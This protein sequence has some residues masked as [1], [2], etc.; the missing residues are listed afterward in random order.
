MEQRHDP[1]WLSFLA[2]HLS[3]L[4]VPNLA[5]FFVAL[6]AL[7]FLLVQTDPGGFERMVLFPDKVLQ[8]ELWRLISFLAIPLAQSLIW[9]VF[10][11]LFSYFILNSIEAE[12]GEFKTTFY[13]LV[14]LVFTVIF[15]FV[16]GYPITQV[17]DF[18]ST[19]FLAAAALFPNYEIRIYF[20]FP[21][22][23][24]VLGWLALG[25]LLVRILQG[26]WIDRLF[27][28][29]IYANYFLFFGPTLLYRIRDWK[30]RR[31]YRAKFRS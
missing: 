7:G 17:S 10:S 9:M 13:V 25:F 20:I 19:L 18:F 15:S 12:W 6:Q 29:A 3:W 31:D 1:K 26:A 21:V 4:G 16:F 22:K 14:S 24:K 11:L 2:K 23:M 27:L 30:R 28:A 5:T 8:G